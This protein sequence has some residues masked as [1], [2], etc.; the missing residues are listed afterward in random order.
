MSFPVCVSGME[1]LTAD[2]RVR[3]GAFWEGERCCYQEAGQG[4]GRGGHCEDIPHPLRPGQVR[5]LSFRSPFH[6]QQ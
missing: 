5:R 6:T 1:D 2:L 4:G 3:L